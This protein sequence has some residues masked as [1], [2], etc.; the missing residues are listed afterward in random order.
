[1]IAQ[2]HTLTFTGLSAQHVSVQAHVASGLP[3]FNLVGL[4]DKTVAE[5]R[6]RIFAATNSLGLSLPMKRITVNLSPADV[7]K[8]G[9]H[10]DLPIIC[11]LLVAMGALPQD[12]LLRYFILGE[13]ALDGSIVS[14]A[15]I[16]P[17]TLEALK[18]DKGII[19]PRENREEAAWIDDTPILAPSHLLELVNHFNNTT[20]I[21]QPEPTTISPSHQEAPKLYEVR[22]QEVAKRALTIAAAGGH[23]LLMTGPPGVGKSMLAAR[24]PRMIPALSSEEILETSMINSIA[25]KLEKGE[26]IH[27]RPFRAPHHSCS[28]AAMVGGGFGKKTN[29]GEVSLAHHGVLFLDELPEFPK[30]ALEALRQPIESGNVT[31]ARAHAHVTY[32]ARFQLVAAMNPCRCGY[33]DDPERACPRAPRCSQNYLSTISGPLMDRIDLFVGLSFPDTITLYSRPKAEDE[34]PMLK[35]IEESR[36]LQAARYSALPYRL[37]THAEEGAIL[38]AAPLAPSVRAFLEAAASQLKL[39]LR[40]CVR[41]LRVARTI[42]DLDLS[43]TIAE[44]HVAEALHYRQMIK[45]V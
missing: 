28:V 18:S 42:A 3:K 39:S 20:P 41:V 43:E 45:K 13:L 14:A 30:S 25:G 6:E 21:A 37:N 35:R 33:V 40:G 27:Q 1:M 29:P 24:L 9:S 12:E 17:A 38:E 15:G 11:A 23:N 34:T 10:F 19:C 4:P 32:P 31:I 44:T 7:N 8:E 36:A 2:T 22:G 26:L 5:S 16:L